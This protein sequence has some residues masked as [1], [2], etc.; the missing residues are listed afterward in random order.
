[1]KVTMTNG[2]RGFT[3]LEVLIGVLVLALALLG[4]AAVFPV[5]VRTQRIA[6][7]T[8]LGTGVLDAAEAMFRNHELVQDQNKG[9]PRLARQM[10]R[11]PEIV[12]TMWE[13]TL[14][15]QQADRYIYT[16]LGGI[17]FVQNGPV[18]PASDRL[19][20]M[21]G[22]APGTDPTL[23]W[24][25]AVCFAQ[26]ENDPGQPVGAVLDGSSVPAS[27]PMRVALFVRRIDPQIRVRGGQNLLAMIDAGAVVPIGSSARQF[28]DPTLDG[29][30]YHQPPMYVTVVQ[31]RSSQT[32]GPF[33]IL[34]VDMADNGRLAAAKAIGQPGQVLID[35]RG[36]VHTVVRNVRNAQGAPVYNEVLL[37]K[38]VLP[39]TADLANDSSHPLQLVFTA[40]VPAAVRVITVRQ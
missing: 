17:R 33:N 8:V 25:A 6:R 11:A 4:L 38:G 29:T 15:P 19:N 34:R 20:L 30:G 32:N 39:T 40:Q 1:V 14:D 31:A 9:L 27:P 23:V 18:I 26:E 2:R 10:G 21:P 28:G 3:L 22:A 37:E 35:N 7:D 13:V 5:V 12:Q 36:G 24:D 16:D